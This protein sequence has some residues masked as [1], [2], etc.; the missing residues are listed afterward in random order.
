MASQLF[1][2]VLRDDQPDAFESSVLEDHGYIR[3]GTIDF[4]PVSA[5]GIE[6]GILFLYQEI[7][8]G[9]IIAQVTISAKSAA[10][11]PTQKQVDQYYPLIMPTIA[12][13]GLPLPSQLYGEVNWEQHTHRYPYNIPS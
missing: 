3:L 10:Y 13:Y 1:Q 6:C 2:V 7:E 11:R 4:F 5:D 9:V 8:T 12:A